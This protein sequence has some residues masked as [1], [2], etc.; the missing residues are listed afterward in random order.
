MMT[1][2]PPAGAGSK[3]DS[4][5]ECSKSAD[6]LKSCSYCAAVLCLCNRCNLVSLL[7]PLK[8]GDAVVIARVEVYAGW[9]HVFIGEGLLD[10]TCASC[11]CSASVL[12]DL[13]VSREATVLMPRQISGWQM[14][15][16]CNDGMTHCKISV[17][18]E[19]NAHVHV[20]VQ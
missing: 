20:M 12:P 17:V 16:I 11:V 3:C 7:C 19:R 18:H 4:K 1:S 10:R 9:Y 13:T 15:I 2:F 8:K 14:S 6:V 5:Q